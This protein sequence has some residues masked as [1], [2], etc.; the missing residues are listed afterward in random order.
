[1]IKK[2]TVF[3]LYSGAVV[4]PATEDAPAVYEA[5]PVTFSREKQAAPLVAALK[6]FGYDYELRRETRTVEIPDA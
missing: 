6:Q 5:K 4:T 3:A 1:M 2:F